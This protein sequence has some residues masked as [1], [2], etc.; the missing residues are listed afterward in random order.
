MGYFPYLQIP[1][2]IVVTEKNEDKFLCWK[3]FQYIYV[4]LPIGPID[5]NVWIGNQ[6]KSLSETILLNSLLIY[7]KV[8][9]S[10][11]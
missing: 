2:S 11:N 8:N 1:G 7:K 3:H 4:C 5:I 9:N 6:D 10:V